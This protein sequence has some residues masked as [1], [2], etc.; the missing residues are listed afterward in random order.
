MR[1]LS[2]WSQIHLI[3]LFSAWAAQAS[4]QPPVNLIRNGDFEANS[5]PGE[6]QDASNVLFNF[7]MNQVHAFGQREGIDI[8]TFGGSFGEPQSGD[9]NIAMMA[10]FHLESE[11]ISFALTQSVVRDERYY[12]E[13][14]MKKLTNST[15]SGGRVQI[16][17][18]PFADSDGFI[19]Y[20]SPEA[21]AVTWRRFRA[22]FIAPLTGDYLTVKV[23]NSGNHWV[24][25]DNFSLRQFILG[26]VNL[27]GEFD[28]LDVEPFVELLNNG[29]FIDEADINRD[30]T[31]NLLDVDPFVELLSGP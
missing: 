10:D 20:E 9:W 18:S 28:L 7:R 16:G 5:A 1:I 26:D 30:G 8:Q 12:L 11:E 14:Y 31:V 2:F 27:D 3:V 23:H 17:V 15:H 25:L 24:G 22:T 6:I 29:G 19:V 13:F 4:G 21:D